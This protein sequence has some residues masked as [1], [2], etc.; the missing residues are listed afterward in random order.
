V[1]EYGVLALGMGIYLL[2]R[3]RVRAQHQTDV[4]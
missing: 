1:V 4:A 3:G 2:T